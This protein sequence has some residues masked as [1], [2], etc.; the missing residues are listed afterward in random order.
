M[1][2][3]SG[4]ISLPVTEVATTALTLQSLE[5]NFFVNNF[6][7]KEN[8]YFANLINN[9]PATSGEVMFGAEISG[10]KGFY[11]TVKMVLD[12][13]GSNNSKKELF[14]VSSDIVESSY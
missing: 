10:I 13:T 3:S 4:D 7:R 1:K 2:A 5:S 14:S 12:N 9:S 6:K 8:K 11:A